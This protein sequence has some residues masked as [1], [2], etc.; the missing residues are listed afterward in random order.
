MMPEVAKIRLMLKKSIHPHLENTVEAFNGRITIEPVG[1]I[2]IMTAENHIVSSV[3]KLPDYNM[4]L[5]KPFKIY[6]PLKI[7][8]NFQHIRQRKNWSSV[9]LTRGRQNQPT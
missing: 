9:G 5:K 3:S 4:T 1:I 2:T 8:L 6:S 7:P